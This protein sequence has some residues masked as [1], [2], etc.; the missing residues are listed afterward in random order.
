MEPD[1]SRVVHGSAF[2]RTFSRR[3]EPAPPRSADVLAGLVT[4]LLNLL[5][6]APVGLLWGVLA[7]RVQV[8]LASA[9]EGDLVQVYGDARIAADGYF[10]A[11]VA[12]AG[13]VAGVLAYLLGRRHGPTVVVAL[14]VGGLL[15]AA[16][17]MLVGEQVGI[18]D[19]ATRLASVGKYPVDAPLELHSLQ[20]LAGW[21]VASLA[22]FLFT[23]LMLGSEP[24][25]AETP[26]PLSSG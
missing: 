2:G 25:A 22:G 20:A 8:R 14:A 23:A 7:P 12:V 1:T 21:P 18:L 9:T 6:A 15:A 26:P 24:D 13:L 11:A 4:L 16:T 10:L 3:V 19:A 17:A 5:V